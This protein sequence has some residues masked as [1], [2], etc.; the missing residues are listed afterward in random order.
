[1]RGV[2]GPTMG[3]TIQNVS[4]MQIATQGLTGS[5]KKYA[6]FHNRRMSVV[7]IFTL[8]DNVS[9]RRT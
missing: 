7:R 8:I 3:G 2:E 9:S 6:G 4:V 5:R 1:M